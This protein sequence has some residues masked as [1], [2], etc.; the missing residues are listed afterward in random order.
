MNQLLSEGVAAAHLTDHTTPKVIHRAPISSY[1][2]WIWKIKT[3]KRQAKRIGTGLTFITFPIMFVFA[4]AAHPNLLSLS[5]VTDVNAWIAEFH[6]NSPLHF[7]H[8]LMLS[9]VPLLLIATLKIKDL[10][11]GGG[12]WFGF[13]GGVL[14]V[15][16]AVFLAADKGALCLVTSAFDTL[17]EDQFAQCSCDPPP[18]ERVVADRL[19]TAGKSRHRDH[20]PDRFSASRHRA[21]PAWYSDRQRKTRN[22][23]GSSTDQSISCVF[24][25]RIP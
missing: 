19:S 3:S 23:Y 18:A 9:S 11:K 8:V 21:Y 7:G 4:Y 12:A 25:R 16:G 5:P 14:A 15:I 6:G 17:P 2:V 24:T 22:I 1:G 20:Q 13:I 10:S